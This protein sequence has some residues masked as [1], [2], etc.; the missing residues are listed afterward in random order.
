MGGATLAE[1]RKA[2]TIQF[3][4]TILA[5]NVEPGMVC[6]MTHERMPDGPGSFAFS[7]G[8]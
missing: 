2:R 6:S 7:A 8:G 4:T 1:W 3:R 5:L